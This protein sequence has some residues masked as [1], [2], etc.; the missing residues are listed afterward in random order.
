MARKKE[1]GNGDG[2]VWPRRNK[3]G[4]IIGYR[5]SYWVETASGPKRRYVSHRSRHVPSW[6]PRAAT[7]SRP[8]SSWPYTAACGKASCWA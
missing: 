4:K 6:K 3:E 5:A 1:R 8:C 7:G 2:D